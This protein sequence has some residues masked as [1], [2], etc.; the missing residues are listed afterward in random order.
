MSNF[1]DIFKNKVL[2]E[3]VYRAGSQHQLQKYE[4]YMEELKQLDEKSVA[5]FSKLD[6]KK[7]TQA[8]DL[9]Y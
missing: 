8:Y 5:W 3:L 2:K 6:I 9:G 7:L 4:R 1:N